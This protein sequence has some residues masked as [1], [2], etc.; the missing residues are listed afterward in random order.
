MRFSFSSATEMNARPMS[1]RRLT[2]TT[3]ARL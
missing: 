3:L 1:E 2:K